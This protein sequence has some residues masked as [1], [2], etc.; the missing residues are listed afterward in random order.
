MIDAANRD[1]KIQ[2][3]LETCEMLDKAK[4]LEA[5]LR[6][7]I[8]AYVLGEE[9]LENFSSTMK[10]GNG[11]GL[12]ATNKI[13]YTLDSVDRIESIIE[14]LCE[15]GKTEVSSNVFKWKPSLSES[16]YKKLDKEMKA[17]IDEVLSIKPGMPTL[18]FI[19]PK[20]P[21]A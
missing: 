2:L 20:A 15:M 19:Q 21:N 11:Y 1:T 14:R 17:I 3:W 5:E 13:N 10:L 18:E 12:K 4:N 7:E 6:R 8:A 16:A 9:R